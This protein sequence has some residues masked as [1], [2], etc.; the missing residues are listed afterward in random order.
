ME[1]ITTVPRVTDALVRRGYSDEDMRRI[2]SEN[3]SRVYRQVM[4]Q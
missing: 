4:A 3:A 2:L 1:D